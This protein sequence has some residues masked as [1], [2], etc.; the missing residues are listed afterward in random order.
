MAID[1]GALVGE[2]RVHG[3][4]YLRSDIFEDELERIFQRGWV[5]VGHESEVAQS[6]DYRTAWVGRAPVL[7][8]RDATGQVHVFLNRCPHRAATVCQDERGNASFLR[9]AY[10]GWAFRNSG[11]LVGVPYESGYGPEFRKEDFG[12]RRVPRVASYRGFVFASLAREGISLDE[13]LGA[14][15]KEQID[16]FCD[17]SP[18][19]RIS[20]RAGTHRYGYNANWKLQVENSIDGYHPNFTHQ[21]FL[22][23]TQRRMGVKIDLFE[24]GSLGESRDLGNGHTMLDSRAFSLSDPATERRVAMVKQLAKPYWEALVERHGEARAEELLR[25]NGTHMNVFPN[26]VILQYQVRTVR[27][28]RV[29][30]TEVHVQPALLEGVPDMLNTM[31]LRMHE[32]FYGPAGGGNPDDLEMFERV[33]DGLHARIDPWLLLARG[34]H[35]ERRDADGTLVGQMTDEVSQRGILHHWQKVMADGR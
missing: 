9:C 22:G 16:L 26:L 20:L 10:H 23:L 12:L 8:T 27:P 21:A 28:V 18:T 17:L 34:R 13:H 5:Y 6:G 25:Y 3:D 30:R 33:H 7:M 31:R 29:D 14:P 32:Q 1:Y 4:I 19:G 15:V 11:E 2:D 35:R 24:G